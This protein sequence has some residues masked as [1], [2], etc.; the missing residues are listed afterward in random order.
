MII[1]VNLLRR[2]RDLISERIVALRSSHEG[3]A[4]SGLPQSTTLGEVGVTRT[5][6]MTESRGAIRSGRG[7]SG[8]VAC[9]TMRAGGQIVFQVDRRRLHLGLLSAC[10]WL[11]AR[12]GKGSRGCG[13][14]VPALPR[15]G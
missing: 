10:R 11:S 8:L 1:E 6:D 15:P 4:V 14:E 9:V 12:A 13:R 3:K 7:R 2:S 5:D